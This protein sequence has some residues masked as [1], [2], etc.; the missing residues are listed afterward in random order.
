MHDQ[1]NQNMVEKAKDNLDYFVY[2]Y[3]ID[4]SSDFKWFY[5]MF[6]GIYEFL[7]MGQGQM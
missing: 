4:S 1:Y 5:T 7:I 3:P 2:F 6:C